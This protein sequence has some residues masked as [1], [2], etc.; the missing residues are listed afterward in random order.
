MRK[1]GLHS[2]E[3][4]LDMSCNLPGM[5][6]ASKEVLT[7]PA[8]DFPCMHQKMTWYSDARHPLKA[9]AYISCSVDLENQNWADGLVARGFDPEV[10]TCWILEGLVMY[11]SPEAVEKLLKGMHAVSATGSRLLVM[12]SPHITPSPHIIMHSHRDCDPLHTVG[13]KALPLMCFFS[14]LITSRCLT[15]LPSGDLKA[16]FKTLRAVTCMSQSCRG[17]YKEPQL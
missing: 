8:C 17:R 11:L 13:M 15:L 5:C 7:N 3:H 2:K 16:C 1:V 12:V 4:Y 10:P 6:L 9:A 14:L